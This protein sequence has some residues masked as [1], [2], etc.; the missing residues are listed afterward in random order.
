MMR[1]YEQLGF[2]ATLEFE[3]LR[4]DGAIWPGQVLQTRV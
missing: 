1:E 3:V 2:T 4:S